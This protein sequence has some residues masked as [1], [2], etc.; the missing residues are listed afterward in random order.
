VVTVRAVDRLVRGARTE[1]VARSCRIS[2]FVEIKQV[3]EAVG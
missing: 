3:I 1:G 2:L